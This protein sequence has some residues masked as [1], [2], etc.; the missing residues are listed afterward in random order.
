MKKIIPSAKSCLS[1]SIIIFAACLAKA[2]APASDVSLRY[3]VEGAIHRCLV[4]LADNQDSGGF[5][6]APD[7]PD[8]SA[9]VLRAYLETPV[10][11]DKWRQ[12]DTVDKGLAYISESVKPDGG[13]Y[14]RGLYSYNTAISLMFLN[15]FR[16]KIG[17]ETDLP[18]WDSK[19]MEE[20]IG[21]ARDFLVDQQQVYA[22]ADTQALSGGIGY[23][24]S[25]EH[26]DMSNTSLAVQALYETKDFAKRN[27]MHYDLDW[28]AAISFVENCQ[29]LPETNHQEWVSGD[30]DNQGGF[31]YFPGDSKAGP[32]ELPSGKTALRSYGSMSYAGLMSFLYAGVDKDD[33]RVQAAVDWLT[34]HYTLEENPNMGKQGLYYYYYTMAKALDAYGED[35]LILEDGRKINW[36]KA[37]AEKLL[38]LQ[39]HPG[40]WVNENGRWMESDPNIVSAYSLLALEIIYPKL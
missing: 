18:N 13:I 9:L 15:V 12:S 38:S 35:I 39:K 2:Q 11:A 40:F 8:L 27:E 7:Y 34:A 19:K 32:V 10:D 6:S 16:D 28:E 20:V 25:Y 17:A 26:S 3:E 4:Y 33:P 29:N 22:T 14:N 23:G 30:P 1:T 5:W 21:S 36:R 37:L 31:V 24:N